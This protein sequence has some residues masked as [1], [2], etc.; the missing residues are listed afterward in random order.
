MPILNSNFDAN[1]CI[2]DQMEHCPYIQVKSSFFLGELR[3][4][5]ISG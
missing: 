5:E 1:L 2:S 3:I 4:Y